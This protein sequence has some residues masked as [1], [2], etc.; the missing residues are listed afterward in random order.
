MIY[1]FMKSDKTTCSG[2]VKSTEIDRHL[3][4][5]CLSTEF[6]FSTLDVAK[7]QNR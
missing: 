6:Q 7:V 1:K 4:I 3:S 2:T 5:T